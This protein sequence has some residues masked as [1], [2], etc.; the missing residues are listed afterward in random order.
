M[1]KSIIFCDNL[2]IWRLKNLIFE[3]I[4]HAEQWVY[5][6]TDFSNAIFG[7]SK[8]D[9]WSLLCRPLGRKTRTPCPSYISH[10]NHGTHRH[11]YFDATLSVS[12]ASSVCLNPDEHP[13]YP[14]WVRRSNALSLPFNPLISVESWLS[15]I[16]YSTFSVKKVL[17]LWKWPRLSL[18]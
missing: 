12:S 7:L 8:G 16:C 2:M 4:R 5:K 6:I 14:R 15:V 18:Q 3:I 1:P 9:Q 11:I 13:C 17:F 10:W